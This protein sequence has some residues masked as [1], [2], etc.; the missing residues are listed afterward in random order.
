MSHFLKANKLVCLF[1][2]FV[3][4]A[5]AQ[6]Q[7]DLSTLLDDEKKSEPISSTFKTTRIV[8]AH[9]IETV[10]KRGLDFRVSHKFGDI[11]GAAGGVQTLYGLDNASNIR[12]AFEYGVTNKLTVGFGRS[13]IQQALDGY[14]K[15]RLL[16]QTTDNKIPVSMTLFTNMVVIPEKNIGGNYS[17]ASHRFS[18]TYQAIVGRKFN[19]FISLQIS[20]TIVHRNFI[21]DPND[22]ND[23]FSLGLGGRIKLTKRFA[24]LADYFWSFSKYRKYG[25]SNFYFPPLGIGIEIETGGHVFHMFFTNSPGIVENQFLVNSSSS[26]N[27]GQAKFG[28]NISRTFG[29]GKSKRN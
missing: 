24:V 9:S 5:A 20:P 27:E 6:S 23:L 19:D 10:K 21:S 17:K 2:F 29:I 8:N 15:Y 22:K 26:W 18:Y 12:I 16:H 25:N 3:N 7:D 13:K 28:F 4:L 11:A 1:C 14:L